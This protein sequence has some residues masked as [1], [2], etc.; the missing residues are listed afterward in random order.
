MKK[1]MKYRNYSLKKKITMKIIFLRI[2][3]GVSQIF[4]KNLQRL[5]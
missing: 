5:N 4:L 3:K 2:F 1:I